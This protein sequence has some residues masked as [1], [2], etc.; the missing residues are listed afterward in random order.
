M[1][2]L[3][4][5]QSEFSLTTSFCSIQAFDGLDETHSSWGGQSALLC[6]LI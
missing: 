5:K 6:L 1:S 2:Q 4:V 3:K